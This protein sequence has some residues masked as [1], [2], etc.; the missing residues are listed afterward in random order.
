M[1]A[2]AQTRAPRGKTGPKLSKVD[3]AAVLTDAQIN[4]Y[5]ATQARV[6]GI[7][8]RVT[9]LALARSRQQ[10]VDGFGKAN[11]PDTLLEIIEHVSDWEKHCKANAAMASTAVARLIC[12]ASAILERDGSIA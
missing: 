7:K 12:A 6:W 3:F 11:G 5:E 9:L 10:L 4:D 2:A 1:S 8:R